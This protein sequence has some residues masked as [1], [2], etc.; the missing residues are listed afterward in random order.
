[1]TT[2]GHH[3]DIAP[4]NGPT[5]TGVCRNCGASKEFANTVVFDRKSDIPFHLVNRVNTEMEGDMRAAQALTQ[6][7]TRTR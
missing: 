6:D 5:S 7:H 4:A 2:C 1:M 3:W